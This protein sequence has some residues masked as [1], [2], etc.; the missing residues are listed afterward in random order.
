MARAL[1]LK[2]K[3]AYQ[4]EFDAAIRGHH[5]YKDVWQPTM[6]MKL[7]CRPDP[8]E[9]A[10]EYD[11][12][13]LGVFCTNE[14]KTL[15]GHIPIEL[16]SL[17]TYFLKAAH[18]NQLTA[19]VIG[20]RKREVGLVVPAKY[21]AVTNCKAVAITLAGKLIEKMDRCKNFDMTFDKNLKIVKTVIFCE[22]E[23]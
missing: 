3:M 8:R 21:T 12:N 19:K 14:K 10:I 13:A 1:P 11:K 18:G 16:S 15:V 17:M 23:Q 4:I 2:Y 9:E 6:G 7:L 5:I 22:I 20:K